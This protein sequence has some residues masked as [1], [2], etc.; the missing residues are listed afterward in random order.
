M[1]TMAGFD[2]S[3]AIR[4]ML[5]VVALGVVT[6]LFAPSFAAARGGHIDMPNYDLSVSWQEPWT[7]SKSESVPGEYDLI[8]LQ[9]GTHEIFEMFYGLPWSETS[10][11]EVTRKFVDQFLTDKPNYALVQEWSPGGS[12]GPL[13]Q[14]ISYTEGGK[15]WEQRVT[16]FPLG[17]GQSA[18]V[19]VVRIAEAPDPFE[20][21]EWSRLITVDFPD[22]FGNEMLPAP[23]PTPTAGDLA[24]AEALA[25]ALRTTAF[26]NSE[27]SGYCCPALQEDSGAT[28]PISVFF[29]LGGPAELQSLGYW[30]FS[31]PGAAAS[32]YE[33]TMATKR[34]DFPV[35]P[36]V[37]SFMGPTATL[38]LSRDGRAAGCFV[39]VDNVVAVGSAIGGSGP[40]T[41]ADIACE[42]ARLAVIH[43]A[44]VAGS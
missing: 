23:T 12:S 24:G 33:V 43:L 19:S 32:N 14:I 6:P 21:R 20:F 36:D 30:I 31:S 41:P 44:S 5:I 28:E 38:L 9:Y 34:Q 10:S 8:E 35:S 2:T 29:D 4:F 16:G 11:E 40:L 42:L 15:R 25:D 39:L 7:L 18:Y 17:D 27:L 26:T 13:P 1:G 3:R 22:T 37:S